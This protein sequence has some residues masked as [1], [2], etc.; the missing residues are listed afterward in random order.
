MPGISG[1][2]VYSEKPCP[3]LRKAESA[4]TVHPTD[5]VPPFTQGGFGGH[6]PTYRHRGSLFK[7]ESE[8]D[9]SSY[10][11][12]ASLY[13]RY[14]FDFKKSGD[15]CRQSPPDQSFVSRPMIP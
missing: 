12:R 6:G 1:D 14:A 7:A 15:A 5:T 4:V 8:G 10:R 9:S 2:T 3:P 11:H 13:T